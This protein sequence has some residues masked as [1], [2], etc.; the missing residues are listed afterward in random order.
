MTVR[1]VFG[2]CCVVVLSL[3]RVAA[4]GPDASLL[5]AVKSGNRDAVRA[6][7]KQPGGANA[8]EPDGTTV[9]HWVVRADDLE[10]ARLLLRAGANAKAVNRYGV[11]PL[12]LA[13]TNGS[14]AMFEA[15]LKAGANANTALPEGETVLM[16]AART[17]NAA[18]L[19]VLLDHGAEVNA[20][21]AWLGEN[22]LMWAAAENHAAAVRILVEAGADSNARSKPVSFPRA[23]RT[24]TVTTKLPRGGWTPLMFAARQG[25]LDAAR[26]LADAGADL[27]LADSDGT[28]ALV[29]AIM[30]AQYDV[31]G[32]L[33][34]QGADPNVADQIGMA[35]LYAAVDMHTQQWMFGRPAPKLTGKLTAVAITK[36]LLVH[37]ANP[38]A[39]LKRPILQRHH[40]AGDPTLGEGT[41]PFIRA[42]KTGDIT[43][44]RLLLEGGADPHATQK[45]RTTA[46][47]VAAG[48]GWRDPRGDGP[49]IAPI[50]E[51]GSIEAIQLCLD[52]GLDINAFNLRGE[53]ALHGAAVRGADRVV[54]FLAERHA[55]L[56]IKN[57]AEQT[58]LDVA[59]SR[60]A[61]GIAVAEPRVSTAALLQ[62]LLSGG[63]AAQD[64]T[65]SQ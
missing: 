12:A 3:A 42:A 20:R 24:F 41:T 34:D 36:A 22:A 39:S 17:G 51:T 46:L 13:A 48:V 38:N 21:E 59:L 56:D 2:A 49:R 35:P 25:A 30:N 33:L 37:G 27:N 8:T 52:Q 5:Q 55:R 32:L 53:T 62:Q 6:L 60:R 18:A 43:L 44:M 61:T 63:G 15:L 4:A 16:T 26:A 1:R 10:T 19:R 64:P 31:A 58:P 45:D 50:T 11:T 54:Q 29:L 9:L 14:A 47:M 40:D 23:P 28:T 7:L 57:K 65:R